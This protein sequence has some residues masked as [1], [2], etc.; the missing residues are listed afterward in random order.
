[1]ACTLASLGFSAFRQNGAKGGAQPFIPAA[2]RRSGRH[3][4]LSLITESVYTTK[5]LGA[6]GRAFKSP[7]P[8]RYGNAG[9]AGSWMTQFGAS[10]H[11]CVLA[12]SDL[13]FATGQYCQRSILL[14]HSV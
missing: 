14:A 2:D 6:R 12:V 10:S 9:L 8:H 1:M 3:P 4:N 7:R 11:G 13:G 5:G